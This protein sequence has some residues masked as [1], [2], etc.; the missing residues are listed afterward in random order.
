VVTIEQLR[1]VRYANPFQ[2][3]IL[4]LDDGRRVL[5]DDPM[6]ISF[7]EGQRTVAFPEGR[8]AIDWTSFDRVQRIEMVKP[9]R[10]PRPRKA[11]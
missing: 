8:H 5:I 11:S 10:A 2:P 9:K 4:V 1:A 3:F 7:S 6:L